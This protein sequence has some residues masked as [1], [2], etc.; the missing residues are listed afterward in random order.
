MKTLEDVPIESN[1]ITTTSVGPTV[2]SENNRGNRSKNNTMS[3]AA[4]TSWTTRRSRPSVVTRTTRV[5]RTTDSSN[6]R[7]PRDSLIATLKLQLASSLK[8]ER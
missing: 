2:S 4:G 1:Q 3:R 6:L 8:R 5:F 7:D